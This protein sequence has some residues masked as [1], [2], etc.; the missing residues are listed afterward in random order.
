[1]TPHPQWFARLACAV[2]LAVFGPL[3]ATAQVVRL[4]RPA[5]S[6]PEAFS[7]IRGM[8]ELPDG[9]L[10]VSD[11]IE[12]RVAAVD[13]ATGTVGDVLTEGA[14]PAN[15][16]LP[17]SLV[18]GPADSTFVVD[19]GNNRLVVLTPDGRPARVTV[20]EEP[21]RLFL[22]GVDAS[23]AWLYAVPSW[24]EGPDALPDD[25][26]RLVRWTPLAAATPT[27]AVVQGTRYR[28][29]RSP[30]QEPRIPTV[31][32]AEQD[33]W[34]V[35]AD[36]EIV[37]VRAKPYRV[38]RIDRTGRRRG[39]PAVPVTTRPVTAADKQR[40]VRAFAL[41][42]PVSGRGPGGGMGRAPMPTARE[43]ARLVEITEWAEHHPPFDAGG[44]HV[45]PDGAVWVRQTSDVTRPA[46]YDVFD[47]TLARVRQIELPLGRSVALVTARWIY[48]IHETEEGVQGIERY[49]KP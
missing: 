45:A 20:V 3:A 19:W 1:M 26:V 38:E 31:G 25:S 12:Q 40:F 43:L 21:G 24:A 33:A 37:I 44:V 35:T 30:S 6:L 48:A 9:R 5:A 32:F 15:V 22:R 27:V 39:G 4:E 17:M 10:L 46:R 18:R 2:A 34:L 8:R 41:A 14:G 49:A 23:G 13:L 11:Y 42:S 28:K 47:T 29:D 36:G 7:F 16:R